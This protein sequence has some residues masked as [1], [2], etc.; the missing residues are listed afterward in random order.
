MNAC[1]RSIASAYSVLWAGAANTRTHNNTIPLTK[2]TVIDYRADVG[3][4]LIENERVHVFV[5][6]ADE[7]D[8]AMA[9]NED[10]VAAAKWLEVADLAGLQLARPDTLCPWFSIYISRWD[11]LKLAQ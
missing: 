11:E 8:L 3:G 7:T 1:R 6:Q 4:G 9:L 10:E 5:G 2:T